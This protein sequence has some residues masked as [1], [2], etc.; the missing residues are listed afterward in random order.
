MTEADRFSIIMGQLYK[1]QYLEELEQQTN[2]QTNLE[3]LDEAVDLISIQK[4]GEFTADVTVALGTWN[5]TLYERCEI[6][7]L[8]LG[9]V[10]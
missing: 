10:G 5:V 2:T 7:N 4:I 9:H 8:R 1:I 6:F 3:E